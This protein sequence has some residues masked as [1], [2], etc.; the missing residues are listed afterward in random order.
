MRFATAWDDIPNFFNRMAW[1]LQSVVRLFE[2]MQIA[3]NRVKLLWMWGTCFLF[4]SFLLSMCGCA[5]CLNLDFDGRLS[6]KQKY[7]RD[8]S[9]WTC[10]VSLRPVFGSTDCRL[11]FSRLRWSTCSACREIS[12][13][14]LKVNLCLICTREGM[15]YRRANRPVFPISNAHRA[16]QL[17]R[18]QMIASFEILFADKSN[19]CVDSLRV[20]AWDNELGICSCD[21]SSCFDCIE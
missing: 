3:L 16:A 11:L 20:I 7:F 17:T 6:R 5:I 18:R 15:A 4:S 9:D 14:I 10:V 1:T 21:S 19:W 12:V 8:R 13:S 2:P